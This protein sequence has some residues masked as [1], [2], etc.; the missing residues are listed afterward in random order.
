MLGK[1][2]AE[3]KVKQPIETLPFNAESVTEAQN[4]VAGRHTTGKLV[5]T[6]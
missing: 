4:R 2:V 6:L 5:I 3:G 1:L